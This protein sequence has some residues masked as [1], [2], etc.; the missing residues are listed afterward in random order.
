MLRQIAQENEAQELIIKKTNQLETND[1]IQMK[2]IESPSKKYSEINKTIYDVMLGNFDL[3]QYLTSRESYETFVAG[4]NVKD[5]RGCTALHICVLGG[6]DTLVEFL[7]S[8]SVPQFEG[9]VDNKKSVMMVDCISEDAN[10]ALHMAVMG[11]GSSLESKM[12]KIIKLLLKSGSDPNLEMSIINQKAVPVV[13]RALI[14][15]T[16]VKS[17]E[18]VKLLLEYGA[19]DDDHAALK[20]A[21]ELEDNENIGILIEKI[22]ITDHE[23]CFPS[24]FLNGET[25]EM[26]ASKRGASLLDS[27]SC[28]REGQ[29]IDWSSFKLSKLCFSWFQKV[30]FQYYSTIDKFTHTTQDHTNLITHIDLSNNKLPFFNAFFF[31]MKNL[32]KLDL[33]KNKVSY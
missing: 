22:Y 14:E 13:S 7:L 5:S 3:S 31:K 9:S 21:I 11:L 16:K 33:S 28:K 29:R 27:M 17:S 6:F 20:A 19:E 18:C 10:T 24:S 2:K 4:M 25:H 30:S 26:S 8:L 32:K 12:I 23:N 15:A 1:E